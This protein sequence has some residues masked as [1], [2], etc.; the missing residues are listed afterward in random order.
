MVND[1]KQRLI[2]NLLIYLACVCGF[3]LA[4]GIFFLLGEIASRLKPDNQLLLEGEEAEP[5]RILS[6]YV[7]NC[8]WDDDCTEQHLKLTELKPGEPVRVGRLKSAVSEGISVNYTGYSANEI[9]S[10]ISDCA[11]LVAECRAELEAEFSAG[12]MRYGQPDSSYLKKTV[13]EYS[14]LPRGRY[15]VMLLPS[16]RTRQ[17]GG[18]YIA[19]SNSYHPYELNSDMH[20]DEYIQT[21]REV[22]PE[23]QGND[24]DH[25][26]YVDERTLIISAYDLSD[27]DRLIAQAEI[28]LN[29]YT[30]WYSSISWSRERELRI[31]TGILEHYGINNPDGYGYSEAVLYDYWQ[32]EEW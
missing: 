10:F 19:Q 20:N 21:L 32:T 13:T 5:E 30:A 28:R 25:F 22:Y 14:D 6:V 9:N 7:W 23:I 2:K 8:V 3:A 24:G 16:L 1:M 18:D 17:I 29:T 15:A 12:E 4:I 31:I 26:R 27:P 11:V